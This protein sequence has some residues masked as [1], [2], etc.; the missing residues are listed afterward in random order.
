MT[1]WIATK[2]SRTIARIARA[3]R[4]PVTADIEGGYAEDPEGVARTVTE[5][6]AAGA[7]GINLEDTRHGTGRLWDVDAQCARIAAARRTSPEL[8][9]NARIDTYLLGI[10]DPLADTLARA[11]AYAAAGADGVFVPCVTD[12][13]TVA[14]ITRAVPVPVNI[15]AGPGAPAVARLAE[16]GVARISVGSGL[17]QCA[18]GA[19][20]RGAERLLRDGDYAAMT[21]G[22][23]LSQV[24]G[25]F[26]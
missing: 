3:V 18:Y 8:F 26:G 17:A 14:A 12:L 1:G 2:R 11:T 7:V 4:V 9:L 5:V 15:M 21:G 10:P 22:L 25:L 24:D 20:L 6:L 13:A 19:L 23:E 16:A